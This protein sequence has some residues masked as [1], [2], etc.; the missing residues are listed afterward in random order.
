MVKIISPNFSLPF[1]RKVLRI[2][3]PTYIHGGFCSSSLRDR[4]LA[5]FKAGILAEYCLSLLIRLNLEELCQELNK[6]SMPKSLLIPFSL[7]VHKE[8]R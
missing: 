5:D 1:K 2:K 6:L 3:L 8:H 4:D 7:K